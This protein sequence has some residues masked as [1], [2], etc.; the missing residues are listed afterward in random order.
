MLHL[1]TYTLSHV[2]GAWVERPGLILL[3]QPLSSLH[4][5][6]YSQTVSTAHS[7]PRALVCFVPEVSPLLGDPCAAVDLNFLLKAACRFAVSGNTAFL[8][9]LELLRR[10]ACQRSLPAT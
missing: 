9:I 7:R 1:C 8:F 6:T 4:R 3:S 10:S 5:S 2:D